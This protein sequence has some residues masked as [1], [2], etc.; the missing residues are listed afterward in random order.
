MESGLES[1]V[2]E[3]KLLRPGVP[4]WGLGAPFPHHRPRFSSSSDSV[5]LL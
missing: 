2:K 4:G 1:V 3:Y 5:L